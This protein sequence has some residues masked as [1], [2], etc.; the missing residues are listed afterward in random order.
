MFPTA[1]NR[2]GLLLL[3]TALGIAAYLLNVPVAWI[4]VCA[5]IVLGVGAMLA[6]RGTKP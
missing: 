1:P 4:A 3:V 5:A 6:R 2:L